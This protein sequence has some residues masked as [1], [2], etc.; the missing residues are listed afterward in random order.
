VER[1]LNYIAGQPRAAA[2]WLDS[3]EPATG[4]TWALVPASGGA[5]VD[6][7]VAAALSAHRDWGR[8]SPA[9]RALRLRRWADAIQ[10]QAEELAAIES[11]DNGRVIAETLAGDMARA[12]AQVRYH[13]ELADK[14]LGDTIPVDSTGLTFTTYEPYGVVGVILPYNAPLAMFFGKVSGALAAGN[15]VVVKPSEHAA[16]STLAAAALFDEVDI[17]PGLVNIVAGTGEAAGQ[18]L[19][20]HRDV[21]MVHF[22]GSTAV[23]RQILTHAAG[24][25]KNVSLELGGKSPNIVFADADLDAAVAGVAAL[26]GDGATAPREDRQPPLVLLLNLVS[27]NWS[28]VNSQDGLEGPARARCRTR[29]RAA[30]GQCA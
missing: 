6:D 5:D 11:R 16:C 23:G 13:A 2:G 10:A 28:D 4:R 9:T 26:P 1:F 29:T 27:T 12:S 14:T 19:A 20:A 18:A 30:A 17:P 25:L 24:N 3:T 15:A 8:A 22:T 21:A 7:A